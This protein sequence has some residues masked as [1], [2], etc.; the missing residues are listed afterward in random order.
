MLPN[1][2]LSLGWIK[3]KAVADDKLH[4]A[5]IMISVSD[6]A[7]NIM[8]KGENTSRGLIWSTG[9][10]FGVSFLAKHFRALA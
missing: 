1:D 9:F 3:L 5:E 7:E 2:N 8:G 6:S 10:C 4:V